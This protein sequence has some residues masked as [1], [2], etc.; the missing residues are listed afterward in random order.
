ML[1]QDHETER[2]VLKSAYIDKAMV[3]LIKWLNG[4]RGICTDY[5]CEGDDDRQEAPY[6]L[7][8]CQNPE[9]LHQIVLKCTLASVSIHRA[10]GP[11]TGVRYKMTWDSCRNLM[12]D[13]EGL[14]DR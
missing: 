5:C 8:W 14:H 6:V 1:P 10:P 12:L 13:I 9:R 7:F 2:I 3:P 4:Y 11:F